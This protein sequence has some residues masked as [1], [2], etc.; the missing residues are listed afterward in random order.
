MKTKRKIIEI[1]EE[2]C[3]GCGQCVI[4]CV[5]GAIRMI[6]GKARLI[7]DQYCDGLGVCLGKCPRDAISI[8]EREAEEFSE[9]AVE[10]HLKITTI[11]E[12]V[13]ACGCPS[14]HIQSFPPSSKCGTAGDEKLPQENRSALSHWPVQIRLVPPQAPFLKGADLLVAADCTPIAYPDFHRDFLVGKVV[15]TGCPKFD[16][17]RPYIDKF[18]QIF[19]EADIRS[20]TALVM[21]VPC[22]QGLPVILQKAMERAGKNIPLE[23][24]VIGTSGRIIKT[25]PL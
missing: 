18:T 22:C 6:D 13:M 11:D 4:A 25:E 7:S 10:Q 23:K 24:I 1:N 15:M 3:D 2:R 12:P 19:E 9:T 5:E 16:D 8:V 21:E 14:T 20:I 17:D